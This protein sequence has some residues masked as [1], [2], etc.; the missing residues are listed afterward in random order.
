MN[1]AWDFTEICFYG[2]NLQGSSI[3]LDDGLALTRRQAIIWTNDG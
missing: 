1:F 2:S 3:G